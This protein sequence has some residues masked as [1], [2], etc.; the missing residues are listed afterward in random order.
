MEPQII[1]FETIPAQE[2]Q[3]GPNIIS[4]DKEDGPDQNLSKNKQDPVKITASEVN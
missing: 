3:I 4:D 1:T 2:E